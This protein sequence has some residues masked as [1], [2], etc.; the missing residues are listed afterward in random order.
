MLHQEG[1]LVISR[2]R[3]TPG[4]EPWVPRAGLQAAVLGLPADL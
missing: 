4:S 1:R 3:T 2:L